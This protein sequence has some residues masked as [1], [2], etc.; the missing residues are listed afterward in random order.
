MT[1]ISVFI[2]GSWNFLRCS[3]CRYIIFICISDIFQKGLPTYHFE[4]L[5]TENPEIKLNDKAYKYF[6]IAKNYDKLTDE[7]QKNFLKLGTVK[8]EDI[9][10]AIGI[11]LEHVKELAT[12]LGK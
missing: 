7:K 12:Q 8:Y 5:C 11:P 1:D 10:T 9:A 3:I 2:L 6:F 4:N